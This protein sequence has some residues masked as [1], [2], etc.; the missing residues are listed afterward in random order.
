MTSSLLNEILW[1]CC[2]FVIHQSIR[3][4]KHPQPWLELFTFVHSQPPSIARAG[5]LLV[6]SCL[7]FYMFLHSSCVSHHKVYRL[8]ILRSRFGC[9][10]LFFFWPGLPKSARRLLPRVSKYCVLCFQRLGASSGCN[11]TPYGTGTRK[12]PV[13]SYRTRG[14]LGYKWWQC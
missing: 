5:F 12:V 4:N 8:H 1:F 6:D 7:K 3:H 9:C 2:T 10:L 14:K 13:S 11:L